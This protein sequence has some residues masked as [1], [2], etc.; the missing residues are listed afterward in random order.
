MS[1]RRYQDVQSR[2]IEPLLPPRLDDYVDAT[3]PVRASDAC[4]G[5][6]DLTALGFGPTEAG[7]GTGQPPFDP[8]L[9]LKVYV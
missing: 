7:S 3:H 5:S 2:T 6:L 9:M 8:A 1:Q 4:V